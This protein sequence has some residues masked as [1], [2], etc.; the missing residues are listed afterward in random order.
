M[1]DPLDPVGRLLFTVLAMVAE[2]EADL[3]RMRTREG[4][5]VAEA[6]G[7]L[8]GRQPKPAAKQ[9]AHL[10]VLVATGEYTALEAAELFG[11]GRSTSYRAIGRAGARAGASVR[12]DVAP[13]AR[14]E[15]PGERGGRLTPG[16][17]RVAAA[18]PPSRR[19]GAGHRPSS[20]S[21]AGTPGVSG[22]SIE[23]G[24]GRGTPQDH[25]P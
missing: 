20:R 5:R 24:A 21:A 7:R 1:H 22:G 6:E 15:S 2:S 10:A 25:M 16:T 8:H 11:V 23:E 18:P 3:I 19:P 4:L 13:T 17:L 12:E 9:E 14:R